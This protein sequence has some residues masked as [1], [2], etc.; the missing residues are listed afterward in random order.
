MN[1]LSVRPPGT[2]AAA[3]MSLIVAGCTPISV[4]E[5]DARAGCN[6]GFETARRGL[7][8]N[9]YV[10]APPMKKGDVDV[11]LD[12][13]EAIEGK[14][15]L[16]LEVHRPASTPGWRAPGLFQVRPATAGRSYRVSWWLKNRGCTIVVSV[17]SEEPLTASPPQRTVLR[18]A[19][20][21]NDVWRRFE[22]VT[23]VPAPYENVRFE[24]S[25]REPGTLWIDAVRIEDVAA[26][27]SGF[28]RPAS[29]S[30]LPAKK[31]A[32]QDFGELGPCM[33]FDPGRVT[34]P[35][36]LAV[37]EPRGLRVARRRAGPACRTRGRGGKA[38]P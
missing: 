24:L 12:E 13:T 10:Y 28:H 11:S 35:L 29:S 1:I 15:S 14:R 30:R 16:R 8:V 6:E 17:R 5:R 18:P 4:I 38:H 9:W 25:V 27:V 21:G 22:C 23:T 33:A 32:Q 7:P 3:L 37:D 36:D 19:D 2:A 31:P 20:T 34:A 26:S